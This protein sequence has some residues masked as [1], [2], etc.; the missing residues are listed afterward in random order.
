MA[1]I[2]AAVVL[3]FFCTS[4]ITSK[5][6]PAI[7]T[8]TVEIPVNVHRNICVVSKDLSM[9]NGQNTKVSKL[10]CRVTCDT[11]KRVLK[12]EFCALLSG[13]DDSFVSSSS[14]SSG[15]FPFCCPVFTPG[16]A[17]SES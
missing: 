4:L 16:R 9:T 2:L 5:E 12:G 17:V 13:Y 3:L 6:E 1:N 10:C 15:P 11:K 14:H 8:V 7:K